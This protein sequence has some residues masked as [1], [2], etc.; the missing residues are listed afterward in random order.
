ME[1]ALICS[2]LIDDIEDLISSKDVTPKERYNN[3]KGVKLKA[4]KRN[5]SIH[6]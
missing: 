5:V 6:I 3:R 2:D 4:R 1:D